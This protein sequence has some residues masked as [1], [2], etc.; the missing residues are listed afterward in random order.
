MREA[1]DLSEDRLRS[2]GTTIF[3]LRVIWVTISDGMLVLIRND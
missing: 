2:D 1:M 3:E